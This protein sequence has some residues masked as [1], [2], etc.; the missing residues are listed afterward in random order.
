MKNK[1][2]IVLFLLAQGVF[3]ENSFA[4]TEHK[5]ATNKSK[6]TNIHSAKSESIDSTGSRKKHLSIEGKL[7]TSNE[8]IFL[9]EKNVLLGG[10]ASA[11]LYFS[12]QLTLYFEYNTAAFMNYGSGT[13][14][15]LFLGARLYFGSFYLGGGA[16]KEFTDYSYYD[17]DSETQ[18]NFKQ[19]T[20]EGYAQIGFNA[21]LNKY[22]SIDFGIN[23][24]MSSYK[25]DERFIDPSAYI[26]LKYTI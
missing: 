5:V 21:S 12:Q 15:K 11:E 14:E 7:T 1:F 19:N 26:G 20:L 8:G 4:N 23:L 24:I 16:V 13:E 25:E 9:P 22:F 2:L 10:G 18:K 17:I 3:V 6:S